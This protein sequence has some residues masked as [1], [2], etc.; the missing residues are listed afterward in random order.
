MPGLTWIEPGAPP[1][2]PPAE[3]ALD[4]PNG[5]LAAGGDLSRERLLAAYARGIFPWYS[6]GE[7]ILWWT[8]DPRCVLFPSEIH[9]PRRTARRMRQSR[10]ELSFDRA[11]DEVIQACAA[12][13]AGQGGTWLLPEM[14]AAYCDL[15]AAGHAHSIELYQGNRL[16]GGLYGVCLG[17][18]FFG[19]SMFS[20]VPD[21][22]KIVLIQLAR[23]LQRWEFSLI[24]CQ[25]SSPHVL[26]MGA[27]ELPRHGFLQHLHSAL[28]QPAPSVGPWTLDRDLAQAGGYEPDPV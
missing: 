28:Q 12:P 17:R 16:V 13:R 24:D 21:A 7:P 4:K 11:F 15:H 1:V 8:P 3:H 10:D 14:R 2:F 27:R 26:R 19:E 6:V 25:V 22:S 9:V 18:M 20:R 23:Q 5:L